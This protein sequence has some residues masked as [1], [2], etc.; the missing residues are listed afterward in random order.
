MLTARFL[1][2]LVTVASLAGLMIY[3]SAPAGGAATAPAARA[4]A[5][6]THP[7]IPVSGDS[8]IGGISRSH[9]WAGYAAVPEHSGGSFRF[10]QATFTVP[11]VN[12]AVTASSFSV[13]WVGLNGFDTSTV[14]QDGIEANCNGHTPV[15][16]AW[17]E[18]YPAN[19]IQAV[20]SVDISPGDAVTAAV[21][22]NTGPGA[23]HDKYNFTLTDVSNGQGFSLWKSCGGPSCKNRSAEV[24][25]EAPSS[26]SVL[27]LADFG[28]ISLVNVH[29]TDKSHQKGGIKVVPL[30]AQQDRPGRRVS[31][32]PD[33]GHPRLALRQPRVQQ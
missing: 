13:H 23:H 14:Q 18:T 10:V 11:S 19:Q 16:S 3:A 20:S 9:N 17:W 27:P 26:A 32:P 30:E 25:T 22:Y 15:Y 7:D 12:C 29:V 6:H 4:Q 28:I 8:A 1:R 31:Q 24:I 2:P 21:Y 33:A 5:V